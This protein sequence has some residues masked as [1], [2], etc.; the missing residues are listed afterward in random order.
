MIQFKRL[1]KV[2]ALVVCA[3]IVIGPQPARSQDLDADIAIFDRYVEALRRQLQIPG[4]SAAIV[5]GGQTVWSK[6]YG[7]Q[8]VEARV[9]ATPDTIYDIASLTKTFTSTL[10]MECVE[11]GTLD[12]NAPISRYTTAIPEAGATVRHVMTHTSQGVPGS[13]YRYDG[14]RY[15]AL[16]AVVTACEG[17]PFRQALATDI[18]DRAAM[19]GSVPGHDL[20]RPDA[21]LASLFDGPTLARY[22]S[23][24]SRLAA[25]YTSRSS[26]F[27]K[28]DYPPR[29]I[30]ASA[31]LLS[32]VVDL[33]KYDAAIDTRVFI[34]AASQELAWTNAVSTTDGR[35]LP[36]GLGWFVQR[37][38][39]TRL[40]WHYGSWPQ[41]SALYL[42][43]PERQLT[44]LLLANSGGL[45]DQFP[46]A[47]GDVDV[48]PFARVFLRMFVR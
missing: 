40:V 31:G 10:I 29:D 16:T 6:G 43:V 41:Y 26:G 34:S 47:A 44:L 13:E 9:P 38:N 19:M 21:S 36:Y 33:A 48:S 3:L 30:S 32:S 28:A 15:A 23:A 7:F 35:Q 11:R 25:P 27:A 45:S 24:F 22:V 39:G 2:G 1:L 46:L 14:S 17:R 42:K 12:L 20:D 5:R 18:L 37:Y 4:L 8:D